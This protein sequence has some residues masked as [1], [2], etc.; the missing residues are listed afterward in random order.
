MQP[1]IQRHADGSMTISLT[2]PPGS[3]DKSLLSAEEQLMDA[4][5]A[6]GCKSM[7]HILAGYDV[8]GA[9][10]VPSNG[11]KLGNR[12]SIIIEVFP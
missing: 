1:K 8:D 5:N 2:L 7:E 10:G 4:L 11:C 3:A 9:P 12:K 6:V